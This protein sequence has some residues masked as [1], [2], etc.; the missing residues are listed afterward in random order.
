[1]H[2]VRQ[3][4]LFKG[5]GGSGTEAP[6]AGKPVGASRHWFFFIPVLI[7]YSTKEIKE[8]IFSKSAINMFMAGIPDFLS[9]FMQF[10]RLH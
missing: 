9:V 6:T 1:M 3:E 2:Q 10:W 7:Y 8:S 4:I 5:T